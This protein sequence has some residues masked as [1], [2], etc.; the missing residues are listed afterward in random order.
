MICRPVSHARDDGMVSALST[1]ND[2]HEQMSIAEK[3]PEKYVY[4]ITWSVASAGKRT[5]QI[6]TAAQDIRAEEGAKLVC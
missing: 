6:D 4:V 3:K 2:G 1:D 5:T